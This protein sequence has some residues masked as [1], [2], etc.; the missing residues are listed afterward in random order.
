MDAPPLRWGILGTGWIA[1][2]FAASLQR[3]TRQQVYAVGSRSQQSADRFAGV[4]G[5]GVAHGTYEA[6]VADA[7]VDVVYVATP[8][9]QHL[10]HARLALEAGR[11]VLVEK[12]LGINAHQARELAE[13]AAAQGLF[14]ME[15]TWTMFL[16]K[17]DVIRRLLEDGAL[18]EIQSVQADMGEHFAP[19]HR[20]WRADLGGG[21][22]LDLGTYPATLATWVL[23]GFESA[24][25]QAV[26]APGG[27][28][29]GQVGAVLRTA[30][31]QLATVHT[32]IL[33]D[34]PTS[35]AITGTEAVLMLDGPF[36]QP[37]RFTVLGHQGSSGSGP[38]PLVWDEPTVAHD[39][40]HFEA[41]EVARRI[42]AGELGSPLRPLS[43]TIA[44]L[45]TMDLIRAEAGIV[46]EAER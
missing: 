16:P 2:R 5:A 38:A 30:S 18:G 44:T 37:G 10:P 45:E 36:Y 25:A 31:G 43:A 17:Y 33:G 13:L 34:T 29:T 22:M 35:A 32:S 14:C 6:L 3:H 41:A 7:R 39:A 9:P 46:F 40:L 27:S 42:A 19:E 26:P 21:P 12:P 23:G 15:A 28:V 20:I 11:H 4:V 24:V 1:E 8:H